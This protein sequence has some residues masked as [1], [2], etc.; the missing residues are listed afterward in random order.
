MTIEAE[1]RYGAVRVDLGELTLYEIPSFDPKNL[2]G[3]LPRVVVRM[4]EAFTLDALAPALSRPY[5]GPVPEIPR[6][7]VPRVVVPEISAARDA[8]CRS[9]QRGARDVTGGRHRGLPQVPES[10][11]A[12]RRADAEIAEQLTQPG[13]ARVR[14]VTA[15][16]P[17]EGRC[18]CGGR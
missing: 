1:N 5:R 7:P 17:P 15:G 4:L 18:R 9:H 11:R 10:R 2:I 12:D 3:T 6:L 8:Y 16:G 14:H 13:G